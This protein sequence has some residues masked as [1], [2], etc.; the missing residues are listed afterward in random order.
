MNDKD[1]LLLGRL[2]DVLG[3]PPRIG[4]VV[5]DVKTTQFVR[6]ELVLLRLLSEEGRNGLFISVDRPHQYMVHLLNMHQIDHGNLTFVDTVAR[7]SSDCKQ[8]E[9]RVGFLQGPRN[10]D[11][12][13]EALREWSSRSNGSGFD[14]SKCS[15]AI[16]DNLN[17]L[18]NFNSHQVVQT[19][20]EDFIKTF[21]GKVTLPMVIDKER[22]LNLF[23]MASSNGRPHLDLS[24]ECI[25][26]I[27]NRPRLQIIEPNICGGI[28]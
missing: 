2:K 6:V 16:V 12:L 9:A 26:R 7:F 8:A 21:D 1:L 27:F 19:F 14:M 4:P 24:T 15:F 18:L 25:P 20:L 28:R 3:N 13:P 10:I 22:N 23:Q 17:T 11:T 5:M